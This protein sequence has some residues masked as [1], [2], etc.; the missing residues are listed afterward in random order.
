[1]PITMARPPALP[2]RWPGWD[3]AGLMT[4]A[5][6]TITPGEPEIF[7]AL[8]GEGASIGRPC[9]FLRLSRCNL[10]CEWCDTAYTWRFEG[11]NRPHKDGLAFARAD[12]QL[13]L[14]EADVAARIHAFGQNRLVITGGEPLLQAPALVRMLDHLSALGDYQVEIET[15]GSVV[16]SEAL[17][18]RVHQYNVSPKLSH[19][20]NPRDLAIRPEALG[21][22]ASFPK[23]FFKFVVATPHDVEEVAAL[24]QEHGLPASHIFLMP[25]GRDSATLRARM[26]WLAD[27]CLMRGYAMTDRLHIHL[28]GDTRGT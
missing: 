7:A 19:S 6:A 23:A 15:N 1:M 20:G 26:V 14:S 24:A 13:T 22:F 21:F 28:S 8:Q 5:L 25:E 16:P 10:A 9:V 17:A 4:L 2:P 11:D 12:N 3:N 18:A 27:L